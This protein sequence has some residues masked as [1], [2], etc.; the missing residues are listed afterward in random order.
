MTN[1][2]SQEEYET[3]DIY[4]AAYLKCCGCQYI[5]RRQDRNGR[6]WWFK[7]SNPVGF[8]DLR[9]AYYSGKGMVS[10]K[11]FG[12]QIQAMKELCFVDL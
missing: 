8:S 12:D 2:Q 11:V 6:R 7:F 10:A 4:L 3:H 9:E 1:L 5:G